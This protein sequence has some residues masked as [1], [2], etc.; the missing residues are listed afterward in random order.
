[1]VNVELMRMTNITHPVD[2]GSVN[3]NIIL[4]SSMSRIWKYVGVVS[5]FRCAFIYSLC[6]PSDDNDDDDDY[7]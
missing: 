5:L 7:P 1:M 4:A 6:V 3:I 2:E